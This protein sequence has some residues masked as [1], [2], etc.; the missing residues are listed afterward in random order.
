MLIEGNMKRLAVPDSGRIA[1]ID[2]ARRADGYLRAQSAHL[3]GLA[4][5][6]VQGIEK[7]FGALVR[8]SS[9]GNAGDVEQIRNG[10]KGEVQKRDSSKVP[11]QENKDKVRQQDGDS[12]SQ[13]HGESSGGLKVAEIN[14]PLVTVESGTGSQRGK[15]RRDTSGL[16]Y[17]DIADIGKLLVVKGVSAPAYEEVVEV[18]DTEGKVRLGRVVKAETG[19]ATIV[20]FGDTLG[21]STTGNRVRFLGETMRLGVSD[22]LLG[23]VFNGLGKPIDGLP[24]PIVET[25]L[26]VN[27]APINPERRALPRNLIRTG[28]SVIDGM[29]TLVRGQKLP[30]F[31]GSGMPHNELAAQIAKQAKIIGGK[32][33]EF[34]VVFAAM[35]V[36]TE[37][38]SFFKK[39]LVKSGAIERSVLYLNLAGDPAMERIITARIALTAAE[40]LAFERNMHVLVIM[41]DMSNYSLA[42]REVSGALDE[43]PGRKAYPG[44][45]YSDLA[46][47]YERAGMIKGMKGSVTLM[48]ILTMPADDVTHPIPDLTGYITEGQI[49]LG[50][51]LV[52]KGFYP[53]V[54]PLSSLSRIMSPA[55]SSIIKEQATGK[56]T[57]KEVSDVKKEEVPRDWLQVSSV[58]YKAYAESDRLRKLAKVVGKET[59]EDKDKMYLKFGDEFEKRY[60][61]QGYEENRSFADTSKLGWELLSILPKGEL[62][63]IKDE[64]IQSHYNEEIFQQGV[65]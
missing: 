35:G 46:S 56:Q 50:R 64:F 10:N 45:L 34:A 38:A 7:G 2:V 22:K 26:D 12:G 65:K 6:G 5:K 21:L 61:N 29:M 20:V 52:K 30:I 1:V 43:V 31:S 41:T 3:E 23:R 49:F 58:L 11:A 28:I 42:L 8:L 13:E 54:R 39:A 24:E 15:S 47:L 16:E 60:L 32:E 36:T 33:E 57:L 17:S 59:M 44:Y 53:P 18:I 51:D 63:E 62:T 4:R 25:Y 19:S 40:Y 14:G 27:G 55:V 48:P 9:D 37:E